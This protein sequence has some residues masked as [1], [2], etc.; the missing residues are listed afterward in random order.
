LSSNETCRGWWRS[1][2]YWPKALEGFQLFLVGRIGRSQHGEVI[3]DAC[4][5]AW[6]AF[7][8]ETGCIRSVCILD[9]ATVNS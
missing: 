4:C 8:T 5:S 1:L 7:V 3:L 2:T 9:C 6:N